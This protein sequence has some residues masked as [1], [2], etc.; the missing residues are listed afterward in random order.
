MWQELRDE[1]AYLRQGYENT[2]QRKT[3]LYATAISNDI[4][5][6]ATGILPIVDIVTGII[7]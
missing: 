4:D 2:E 5:T 7:T 6:G 1:A 3:T